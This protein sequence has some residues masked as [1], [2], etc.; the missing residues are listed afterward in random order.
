MEEPALATWDVSYTDAVLKALRDFAKY[1]DNGADNTYHTF[2]DAIP[3]NQTTPSFG[4]VSA[5][6]G[7]VYEIDRLTIRYGGTQTKT[8]NAAGH[9][10]DA[11]AKLALVAGELA[12]AYE[13][14]RA[15]M[16]DALAQVQAIMNKDLAGV[17]TLLTSPLQAGT[18]PSDG[19]QPT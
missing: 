2:V 9:L 14:S 16:Q 6:Y 7:K 10:R 19:Q 3:S 13:H 15:D 18:S 8:L 17:N 4:P 5:K 12:D 1:T 11:I